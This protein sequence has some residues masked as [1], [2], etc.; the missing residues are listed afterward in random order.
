[1]S[2]AESIILLFLKATPDEGKAPDPTSTLGGTPAVSRFSVSISFHD[3]W[4]L[5]QT[6]AVV[7]MSVDFTKHASQNRFDRTL[8][9]F[10]S[11]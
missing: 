3:C 9:K 10:F 2:Y 5:M 4:V 11:Q 8:G 7:L 6:F 1:M